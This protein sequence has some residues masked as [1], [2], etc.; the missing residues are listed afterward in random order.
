MRMTTRCQSERTATLVL[1]SALAAG[2]KSNAATFGIDELRVV[3]SRR[4]CNFCPIIRPLNAQ[5]CITKSFPLSKAQDTIDC[6]AMRETM[7]V[8]IIYFE[9]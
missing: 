9:N 6:A 7:K 2:E 4:R 3:R 8:Q 1:K 5:K